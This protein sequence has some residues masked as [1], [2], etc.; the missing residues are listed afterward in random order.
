[1]I[2]IST[3]YI[4]AGPFGLE[5]GICLARMGLT[6]RIIGARLVQLL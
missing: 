4:I 6:F 1:M 3:H 5:I 2:T